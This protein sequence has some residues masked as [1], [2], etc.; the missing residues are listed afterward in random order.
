MTVP[1]KQITVSHTEDTTRVSQQ[2]AMLLV[3]K[4]GAPQAFVCATAVVGALMAEVIASGDLDFN[5]AECKRCLDE[6]VESVFAF[7]DEQYGNRP[8]EAVN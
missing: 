8:K 2:I 1:T 3:N 6:L 7:I 4:Y 5:K